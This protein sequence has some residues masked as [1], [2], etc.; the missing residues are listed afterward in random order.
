MSKS[1][2]KKLLALLA[3]GA[4]MTTAAAGVAMSRNFHSAA[5]FAD[6]EIE[7][8]VTG[9]PGSQL[10]PVSA[11]EGVN[12]ISK[13]VVKDN[14]MLNYKELVYYMT[15]KP[16]KTGV[17]AFTHS[18]PDV[19]VSE[20]YSTEETTYGEWDD[21]FSV[22]SVELTKDVTYTVVI[23]NFDWTVDLTNYED[24]AEYTLPIAATITVAYKGA[25][26]GSTMET[27][28]PYTVGDTMYVQGNRDVW[29]KFTAETGTD[30]YLISFSGD[31][32]AYNDFDGYLDEAAT[33][34]SNYKVF[35]GIFDVYIRVT[36]AADGYTQ[37]Q[38]LE[39]SKQSAGSCIATAQAIPEN[40]VVG[41]GKWYTYTVGDSDVTL[42][43]TPID[44]AP[45]IVTEY[46]DD[47]GNV[48]FTDT[49]TL[50]G[51]VSVYNGCTLVD[52]LFD[53]TS[54]TLEANTTYKFFAPADV[55]QTWNDEGEV[56]KE[57]NIQSKLVIG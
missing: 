55:Y 12:E 19:G 29:Y 22:Y 27:A 2:T 57:Y 25:A 8:E 24:G 56:V 11:I 33:V 49:Y 36:P 40:G 32:V 50:V 15:F 37:A 26:A 46:K 16:A 43:L 21:T 47:E 9:V 13:M 54:I 51:S 34:T 38:V 28:L 39:V 20:I 41:D 6:T 7:G 1:K 35:T 14:K 18:N 30:Y 53:G 44:N 5:A 3:V 23:N 17:Y 4:V 31:A 45:V 42:S 10:N 48:V 52:T